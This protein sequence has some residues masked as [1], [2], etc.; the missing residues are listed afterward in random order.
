MT[1]AIGRYELLRELIVLVVLRLNRLR[2]A[3]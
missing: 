3:F 2:I 1:A